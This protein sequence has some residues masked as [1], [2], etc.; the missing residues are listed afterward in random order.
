V[1]LAN[2]LQRAE[3]NRFLFPNEKPNEP[4]PTDVSD[5]NFVSDGEPDQAITAGITDGEPDEAIPNTELFDYDASFDLIHN[6]YLTIPTPPLFPLTH[7]D[8]EAMDSV[9]S[10]AKENAHR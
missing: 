4:T 7:T 3:V 5:S 1:Q 8:Q 2:E 10:W 9:Q 6:K